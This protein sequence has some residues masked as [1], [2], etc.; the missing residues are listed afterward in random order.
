MAY[1]GVIDQRKGY[2]VTI[3]LHGASTPPEVDKIQL[4]NFTTALLNKVDCSPHSLHKLA[5]LVA[6]ETID[7]YGILDP[8]LWAECSI[9]TDDGM[10]YGAAAEGDEL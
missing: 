2:K 5:P 6:R 9:V 10:I 7:V 8:I 3:K 4:R 1:V